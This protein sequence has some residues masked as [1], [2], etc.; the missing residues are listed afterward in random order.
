MARRTSSSWYRFA[1]SPSFP[2]R[3]ALTPGIDGCFQMEWP[4]RTR[5]SKNPA[6]RKSAFNCRILRGNGHALTPCCR[7]WLRND[8]PREAIRQREG[9]GTAPPWLEPCPRSCY[10]NVIAQVPT[11]VTSTMT[12]SP[13]TMTR[14]SY[15]SVRINQQ[16]GPITIADD[17]EVTPVGVAADLSDIR[18]AI[19]DEDIVACPINRAW[20]AHTAR[21]GERAELDVPL[22]FGGDL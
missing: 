12:V 10:S 6:R 19:D 17:P 18:F 21:R 16:V 8:I 15:G 13:A 9:S 20:D 3:F 22:A 5:S 1:S 4:P 2:A 7:L 14:P 11:A